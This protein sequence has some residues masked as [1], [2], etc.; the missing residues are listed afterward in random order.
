MQ[1]LL[2]E[3]NRIFQIKLRN[4]LNSLGYEVTI[5]SSVKESVV[6]LKTEKF[7]LLICD[8]VL[9]DGEFFDIDTVPVVPTIFITAYENPT[10][11][12]KALKANNAVFI[13][14][15]FSDLTF[16]AAVKNVTV[17]VAISDDLVTVFGKY[18]NP[19]TIAVSEIE[20]IESEGNYSAIFTINNGKYIVKRSAKKIIEKIISPDFVRVQRSTYI[21]R[22]K[23][24][25][26]L[27][28]EN[29]IFTLNQEFPVSK[30]YRKNIYEFHSIVN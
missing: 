16:I 10:Y 4:I 1:A 22:S 3:D 6:C 7:D 28:A 13:V 14:K 12:E 23:V 8:I 11:M 20:A 29:K 25:R 24:T 19:I 30:V 9:S 27:F 18:K 17:K 2:I 5:V 15:P 26:V 21:N